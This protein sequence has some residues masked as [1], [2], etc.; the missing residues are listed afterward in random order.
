MTP[1][2]GN[3]ASGRL[4]KVKLHLVGESLLL[5]RRD[6]SIMVIIEIGTGHPVGIDSAA[7]HPQRDRSTAV[8]RLG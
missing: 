3:D 2:G 7:R 6:G 8:S 5:A 4:V 1:G